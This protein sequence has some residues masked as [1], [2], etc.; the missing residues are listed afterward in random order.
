[1]GLTIFFSYYTEL[2][3]SGLTLMHKL[4]CINYFL[5]LN[6]MYYNMMFSI[7]GPNI[8]LKDHQVKVNKKLEYD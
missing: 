8:E 4:I 2:D 5:V 1:M 7:G 3:K 6:Y